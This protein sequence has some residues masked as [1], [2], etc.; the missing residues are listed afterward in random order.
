M[1]HP[2]QQ[3]PSFPPR[4]PPLSVSV[5]FRGRTRSFAVRPWI[6][7]SAVGAAALVATTVVGA[8]AFLIF[9]DDLV[10]AAVSRQV[11]MQYSYEERIAAL[12][13][14]LDLVT[15]RH[16]VQS[17]GVEQQLATLLDRQ[18][19]IERRQAALDALV[20]KAQVSG[21]DVA[22]AGTRLPRPR[23]GDATETAEAAPQDETVAPLGYMPPGPAANDAITGTLLRDDAPAS[24]LDPHS[25]LPRVQSSLDDAQA[26]QAHA[27]D[28]LGS[29]VESEVQRLS[30]AL[31]PIGIEIDGAEADDVEAQGGP[32]VP[33]GDM[34]F[35][36]RAAVLDRMLDDVHSLR[37]SAAEMPL[38]APLT[39]HISSGF[40][41][42]TDPFLKRK[43]F[44]PGI[45]F[46]AV[47]GTLVRATAPGIVIA[48]GWD[49]GYG[50]MVE[51]RHAGGVTTRYGHLSATLVSKGDKVTLGMAIG[52]VG[53]TGRSTGPHLHYETRRNGR[54][55]N[56]A[57]F[58][59]AA[60]ALDRSS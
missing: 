44:H 22:T 14:E 26:W 24:D 55:V 56:P 59:A 41:Y 6:A 27:L 32:Y 58:F 12:R 34:R 19:L 7:G 54:P 10:G 11:Q 31:M 1:V 51:I 9:R 40:G 2:S 17:E 21:I 25:V 47:A 16:V 28:A 50:K 46:A 3:R 35:A 57:I 36:E 13:S 4:T 33:V 39:A 15:S 45:D 18:A 42:R 29:T 48:S 5:A 60:K 23:P 8:A 52:R 38:R 20:D 30:A 43:A 49:G 53:S 37:R